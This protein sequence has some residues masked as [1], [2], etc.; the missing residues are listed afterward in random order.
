MVFNLSEG[1]GGKDWKVNNFITSVQI[2]AIPPTPLP[3]SPWDGGGEE[4]VLGQAR[5]CAR[6]AGMAGSILAPVEVGPSL[7]GL[8]GT[9]KN[10]EEGNDMLGL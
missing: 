10:F 7:D 2:D 4:V 3:S 8:S 9:W 1:V 6:S 5:D